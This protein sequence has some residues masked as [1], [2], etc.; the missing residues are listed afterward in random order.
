VSKLWPRFD[1][2]MPL[3]PIRSA[4]SLAVCHG[5]VYRTAITLAYS[6]WS[7]GCRE[8][9]T[10]PS[11]LAS[12]ARVAQQHITT[13][14]PELSEA[15]A[16]ICPRLQAAYAD[17][18]ARRKERRDNAQ[19]MIAAAAMARHR[20]RNTLSEGK[21]NQ[22]AATVPLPTFAP[23]HVNPRADMHALRQLPSRT[24]ADTGGHSQNGMLRPRR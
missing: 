23:Q 2:P 20:K 5:P 16:E 15:L 18:V 8:L 13:M 21:F 17:A 11:A 7:S 1:P 3:E 4:Q 14:Q 10:D 19:K 22:A 6:Y 12:I 24:Q 9:P